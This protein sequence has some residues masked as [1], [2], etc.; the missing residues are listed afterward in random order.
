MVPP[1]T[2]TDETAKRLLALLTSSTVRKGSLEQMRFVDFRQNLLSAIERRVRANQPV[3][4]TLMAFPFKVPNPAK[5]GSRRL[6]DL[7]ELAA[8][9]RIHQLNAKVKSVY[10]AG[11]EIHILH[12]GSYI[13][14]VFG[15]P[16]EE[17]RCYESHF[18]RMV[19]SLGREQIIHLHDF[20]ALLPPGGLGKQAWCVRESMRLRWRSERESGEWANCFKKTLGMMNLRSLPLPDVCRLMDHAEKGYLPSEHRELE[21]RVRTAMLRYHLRDSLLHMLD[22]RPA[23]FPD[24]IHATTRCR[25]YRLAIWMVD[26]GRSLL[27]WHGIG[28][29]DRTGRWSV[30]LAREVVGNPSFRPV[31][32]DNEDTPF[33]YRQVA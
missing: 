26:R 2:S 24:A 25:P 17:V 32:L 4:L 33:F 16:L 21:R 9:V 3:Q 11:M 22:P 27:P 6:P 20:Q 23:C 15:V 10:P 18:S 12:D 7:A 31:F 1:R 8:L 14:S 19:A 29:I 28:V 13:A 5:V 30:A